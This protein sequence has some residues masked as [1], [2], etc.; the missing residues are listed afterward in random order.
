MTQKRT[1]QEWIDKLLE[2]DQATWDD[3]IRALAPLARRWNLNND[4]LHD[5]YVRLLIHLDRGAII[6]DKMKSGSPKG[7]VI[8]VATRIFIDIWR[9]LHGEVLLADPEPDFR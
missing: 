6:A 8:T 3:L 1:R 9:G 2:R 7:W 4:A 5:A